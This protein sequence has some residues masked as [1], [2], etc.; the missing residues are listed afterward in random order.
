MNTIPQPHFLPDTS[1]F[2]PNGIFHIARH[3]IPA[4]T[5][6]FIIRAVKPFAS[7]IGIEG[8]F[9]ERR[10]AYEIRIKRHPN[11]HDEATRKHLT[12]EKRSTGMSFSPVRWSKRLSIIPQKKL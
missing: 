10:D 8:V 7:A 5:R 4:D 6:F 1:T 12:N 3:P 9:L 11:Y 2:S